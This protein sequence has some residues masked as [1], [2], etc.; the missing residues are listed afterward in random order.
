MVIRSG[1][2]HIHADLKKVCAF[3]SRSII[4]LADRSLSDPD[5]TDVSTVRTVMSLRGLNAPS[6]GHIVAE[7]CD[8]DNEELITLV[9]L[10]HVET[11]VSHDIIGRLMIQCARES[12][13]AAVSNYFLG[14]VYC[15]YLISIIGIFL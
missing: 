15:N 12:G 14:Y 13:L 9:G 7:V 3:S 11:V 1:S 10:E 8:I 4:I 5:M 2:P 6:I